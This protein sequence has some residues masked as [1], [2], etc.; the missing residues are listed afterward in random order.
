MMSE[1]HDEFEKIISSNFTEE[2][3]AAESLSIRDLH[4]GI[5]AFAETIWYCT[6][7]IRAYYEA[8][9]AHEDDVQEPCLTRE[10][11]YF[12]KSMMAN[13]KDFCEEIKEMESEDDDEDEDYL[14][15]ED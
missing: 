8:M 10:A 12:I 1:D 14:E 11:V 2:S 6:D 3:P 15:D 13:A 4:E 9:S 5:A 7:F